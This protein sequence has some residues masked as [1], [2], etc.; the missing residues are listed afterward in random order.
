MNTDNRNKFIQFLYMNMFGVFLIGVC[1]GSLS[2]NMLLG[3]EIPVPI[4]KATDYMFGAIGLLLML[5]SPKPSK[6]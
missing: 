2:T 4:I 1:F 5:F 3:V 6:G